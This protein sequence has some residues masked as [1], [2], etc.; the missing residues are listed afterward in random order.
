[1]A[2]GVDTALAPPASAGQV[3]ESPAAAR[4]PRRRWRDWKLVLGLLMVLGSGA[5]GAWLLDA[6]DESVTVWSARQT[7]VAGTALTQGDLVAVDVGMDAATLP[8]LAGPV[9]DGYVVTRTVGPGELVPASAV[10]PAVETSSQ[11]RHVA[12][13]VSPESL[14]GRLASGDR[15]DVWV[16]PDALSAS[17][18]T[19][20]LVVRD[21]PVV[22]MPATDSG[23]TASGAE[24]VILVL[25]D[26]AVGGSE[27][28]DEVTAQ[29]VSASAQGA[30]VLTLNP[31]TP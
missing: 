21:A 6:A 8:Y 10:A 16:V 18:A 1:V 11:V 25:H 26:D 4:V 2:Y 3:P 20:E 31:V 19:A 29:L 12:V 14:P 30:V 23:L 15:V 5:A 17:E 24:S 27:R 22:S 9:P 7:L 13:A 28:L